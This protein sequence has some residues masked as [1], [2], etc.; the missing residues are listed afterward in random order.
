MFVVTVARAELIHGIVYDIDTNKP[1][2]NVNIFLPDMDIGTL[3]AKTGSIKFNS[4]D[5]ATFLVHAS[6]IGYKLFSENFIID[7]EITRSTQLPIMDDLSIATEEEILN[8]SKEN[9]IY[10]KIKKSSFFSGSTFEQKPSAGEV[11][12]AS[13]DTLE[14]TLPFK[15]NGIFGL[16][17]NK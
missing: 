17:K 4:I 3:T 5:S 12:D 15:F 6:M 13:K 1:I 14:I 7:R 11:Y 10:L 2:E 9:G 8:Y 16:K